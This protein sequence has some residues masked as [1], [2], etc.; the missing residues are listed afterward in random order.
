VPVGTL[1]ERAGFFDASAF[2]RAFRTAY[3]YPPREARLAALSGMP[4][5]GATTSRADAMRQV[6]FGCLLRGISGSAVLSAGVAR[7]RTP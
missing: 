7:D 2:S 3:G 5:P 4:L 6:D 1:A